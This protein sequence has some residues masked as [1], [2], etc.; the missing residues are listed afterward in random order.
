MLLV[1]GFSVVVAISVREFIWERE[2]KNSQLLQAI[3]IIVPII[4]II[5]AIVIA[6][7]IEG[8]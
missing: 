2:S 4:A 3:I 1:F 6:I 8:D 5:I 7:I